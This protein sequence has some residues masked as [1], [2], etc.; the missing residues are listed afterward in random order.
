MQDSSNPRTAAI[1]G[2]G[3]GGLTA[4][5]CLARSG[6]KVEIFESASRLSETGAGLQLSPNAMRVLDSL[7][8]K[9]KLTANAFLP[10]A[11]EVRQWRSG[12][13]LSAEKLGDVTCQ[14]WGAP[15]YHVHRADLQ[16]VLVNAV[17]ERGIPLHLGHSIED[18]QSGT[19]GTEFVLGNGQAR[20]AAL[21]IGA[22]G[23]HSRIRE[24]L[25]GRQNARF[26]G[27]V[28][29]RLLIP[30]ALLPADSIRPVASLWM[31]PGAHFVHYYVRGGNW[32]NCVC[33]VE[34]PDWREES[35][36]VPGDKAELKKAFEGWHPQIGMLLA[37]ADPGQCFRWALFDREPMPH[38]SKGSVTLLGDACHPTLPFLAQGAAMAIE[39]AA[40]LASCL[41]S[42]DDIS[43]ALQR[44]ELRRRS[45]TARVQRTSRR[46]ARIYHMRGPMAWVRN[47]ALK[48]GL[49]STRKIT[50]WLYSY[51]A[52]ESDE[53]A[54]H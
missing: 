4:A 54:T 37:A 47:L 27:H 49:A 7:G 36:T 46:N 25:W 14:R 8:L 11:I 39:D 15:Y 13:I 42:T 23:I 2:A 1:A 43:S 50:D 45:R 33:V 24:R 35:W 38:W 18:V 16:N 28:A 17:S 6:W 10:E 44:Y 31:G 9:E 29:W 26:T 53:A 12:R 48:T 32:L 51:N 22:D 34:Q 52:L 21:L 20:N 19:R 3:I 5:L 30:S 41:Q 40:V